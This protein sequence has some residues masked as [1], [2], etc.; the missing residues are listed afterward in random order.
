[1]RKFLIYCLDREGGVVDASIFNGTYDEAKARADA[2]LRDCHR[3][4]LWEAAIC[5]YR[6][7]AAPEE[8]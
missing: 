5:L 4:E 6:A 8:A 2:K 1:M 3:V 7:G